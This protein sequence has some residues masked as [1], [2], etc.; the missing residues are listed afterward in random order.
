MP[1]K[2]FISLGSN[3]EPER[4]LPLAAVRL[5]HLGTPLA[6]SEVFENPAI[7][8]RPQH[9]FLNAAMLISTDLSPQEVRGRLRRIE[10][11]LGRVRTSDKYAARS[12]DLDLC[13]YGD[14]VLETKEMTIPDPDILVRPYLAVVLA[15]LDPDHRHP[16]TGES[17]RLIA[18]RLRPSGHLVRRPD[19]ALLSV[20]RG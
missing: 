17:L 15:Q 10:A 5:S 11:A 19:L 9:A 8:P 4:H 7:G 1:E 3:V 16:G 18:E 14:L 12:I 13:L 6:V 2:A 20:D